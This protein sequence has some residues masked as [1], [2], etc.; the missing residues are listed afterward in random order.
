MVV[1]LAGSVLIC[2]HWLPFQRH[3]AKPSSLLDLPS[4]VNLMDEAPVPEADRLSGRLGA[5][6]TGWVFPRRF[7]DT[8]VSPVTSSRPGTSSNLIP[9]ESPKWLAVALWR[10]RNEANCAV[11][12]N[13]LELELDKRNIVWLMFS[14]A[15]IRKAIEDWAGHAQRI[16]SQFRFDMAHYGTDARFAGLLRELTK[17]SVEFRTW[18]DDHKVRGREEAE[19]AITPSNYGQRVELFQTTWALTSRLGVRMVIYT[20]CD[21]RRDMRV[22]ECIDNYC[23]KRRQITVLHRQND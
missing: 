12:G 21:E 13:P 17:T 10:C 4:H 7:C 11:F 1:L 15:G 8:R 9:R 19:K 20:P 5:V 6:R 3:T 14:T 2:A 22:K 16:L 23:S 18:W